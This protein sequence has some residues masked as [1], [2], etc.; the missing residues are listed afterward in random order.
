MSNLPKVVT[1]LYGHT[2]VATAYHITDYPYGFK[3]RCEMKVWLEYREGM[4]VRMVTQT[5]NPKKPGVW[6]KPKASTYCRLTGNLFLDEQNH[7]HWKGLVGWEKVSELEQFLQDFPENAD[8][9]LVEKLIARH[10]RAETAR[11]ENGPIG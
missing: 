1:P 2:S 4:G 10:K 9:E 8:K 6:N 11:S 3:L 5:S 7:I